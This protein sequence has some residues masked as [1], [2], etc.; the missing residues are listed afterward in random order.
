MW[1]VS[2]G[3]SNPP[4]GDGGRVSRKELFISYSHNDRAF[5]EQFWIHLSSLADYGLEHWDDSKIKP[6]DIWLEEIERAL[7]RAQ[8]A[9]LLVS[10]DFLASTFIQ[11]KELPALFDA[12]KKD[13]LKILWLPIRPCSWKRHR[14]IEQ[15]QSG[16]SLDPTL[17]EMDE[18]KRDREMVKITDH[19]HE[20]FERI[21]N[22]QLAAQQAAEA[23]ALAQRQEAALRLAEQ[24]AQRKR[25]ETGRLERLRAESET[26][27][28]AE[29]WRAQ[30][31]KL[32]KEAEQLAREEV[33]LL[34]KN[35]VDTKAFKAAVQELMRLHPQ[36]TPESLTGI[37]RMGND[38]LATI[39]VPAEVDKG[40]IERDFFAEYKAQ[41]LENDSLKGFWRVSGV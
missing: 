31:E 3:E 2:G 35:G 27:A 17:A 41:R 16:G 38:V 22:E 40:E 7:E 33:Q 39:Q 21:Q 34:I 19:I 26:R 12:A 13:G 18:V 36:I 37:K 23:E 24:D 30:A 25:E 10:Q 1:L 4:E 20:L 32:A 15:Y 8:V 5:L 29:R 9:L 11:R 6:G 28:E 14:Q